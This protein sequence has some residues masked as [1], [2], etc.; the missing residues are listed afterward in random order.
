[1]L[2]LAEK[3][4]EIKHLSSKFSVLGLTNK[5]LIGDHSL[6][7]HSVHWGINPPSKT[8]PLLFFAK[9]PQIC[10]LPSPHIFRQFPT[11]YWFFVNPPPPSPPKKKKRKKEKDFSV[12]P[13]NIK[14]FHPYP[15][16][17]LFKSK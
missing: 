14:I 12:N 7:L 5:P 16:I 2:S 8:P 10:Q 17:P 3:I 9:L 11:I 4:Q 15:F 13:H 6:M 1:M